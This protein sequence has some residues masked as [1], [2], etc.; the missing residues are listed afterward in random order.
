VTGIRFRKEISGEWSMIL[1]GIL[2][3]IFGIILMVSPYVSA[4]ILVKTIGIIALVGGFT[5]IILAF[6]FRKKDH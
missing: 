5:L 1:G 4:L 2:S 3:I 6:Q